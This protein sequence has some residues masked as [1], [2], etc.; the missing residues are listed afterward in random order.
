M[1]F[2]SSP[3]PSRSGQNLTQSEMA[4]AKE[5]PGALNTFSSLPDPANHTGDVAYTIDQGLVYSN[6][7]N[8]V[9]VIATQVAPIDSF[10][11]VGDSRTA[12]YGFD[13]N[14][15][16]NSVNATHYFAW[17]NSLLGQPLQVLQNFGISGLRSDQFIAATGAAALAA[18]SQWVH[19]GPP[20]VNDISQAASGYTT[21][22]SPFFSGGTSVNTSNVAAVVAS[23]IKAYCLACVATGK[24]VLLSTEHGSTA[25]NTAQVAAVFQL[26]E[27]LRYLS[28]TYPSIYL[29]DGA[30]DY[31]NPTGSTTAIVFRA[32]YS[33]DGVHSIIPGGYA[34]GVS[35]STFL[36]TSL[37]SP[38]DYLA[39]N[40][41]DATTTNTQSL[42]DNG[43]FTTLTGGSVAGGLV[44]TSGTIPANWQMAGAAT[45]S[46]IVTSGANAQGYGNDLT[47]AITA[48]AADSIT[49]SHN[50][51]GSLLSINDKVSCAVQAQVAAGSSNLNV[52]QFLSMASNLSVPNTFSMYGARSASTGSGPTTAYTTTL[53]C[54]FAGYAAGATTVGTS[55][56]FINFDF[57]AAGSATV[58][59]RRA[60]VRK[61]LA[62]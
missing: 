42:E 5:N 1:A 28:L 38:N 9:S 6:G 11:L 2:D 33:G 34:M 29:W 12:Q 16:T 47:L 31:W 27:Y 10:V 19:I 58:T 7:L 43:L 55:K 26:N 3:V 22:T 56:R 32:G 48:G 60:I 50:S 24:K 23:Q 54:P 18:R 14:N 53:Y 49:F 51:F 46:V 52:W 25:F 41:A 40:L 61:Q 21:V 59:L 4:V 39:S 36:G 13:S 8:W 35:L 15:P 57:T 20:A 17:A 45:S 62:I 30:K 44:L 37:Y